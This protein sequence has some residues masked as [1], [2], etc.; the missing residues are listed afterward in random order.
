MLHTSY[1]RW[2]TNPQQK[3]IISVITGNSFLGLLSG[4]GVDSTSYL[5]IIYEPLK[6]CGNKICRFKTFMNFYDDRFWFKILKPNRI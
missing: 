3:N 4:L 5:H 6:L 2:Q 1:F